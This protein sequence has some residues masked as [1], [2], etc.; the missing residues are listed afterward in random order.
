MAFR[1]CP[2]PAPGLIDVA[3]NVAVTPEIEDT[4]EYVSEYD[5]RY[6][7][8]VQVVQQSVVELCVVIV[9]AEMVAPVGP[10]T[11]EE[12][13]VPTMEKA[14]EPVTDEETEGQNI[15]TGHGV[16]TDCPACAEYRP[17]GHVRQPPNGCICT[18]K[19][20]LL[21][22]EPAGHGSAICNPT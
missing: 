1:G 4:K 21:P 10:R 6:D 2:A 16:H 22:N 18:N 12:H 13:P 11:T 14:P 19:P 17:M 7:P 3:H 20:T 15:P 8:S 9:R 5:D